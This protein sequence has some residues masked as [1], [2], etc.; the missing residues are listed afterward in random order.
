MTARALRVITRGYSSW[1]ACS[2]RRRSRWCR[3]TCW[4]SS[5]AQASAALNGTNHAG[6]S[7]SVGGL[8]VEAFTQ[9]QRFTKMFGRNAVATFERWWQ[10]FEQT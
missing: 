8:A 10:V 2:C 9:R 1:A 6:R 4:P 3:R 5:A 7:L